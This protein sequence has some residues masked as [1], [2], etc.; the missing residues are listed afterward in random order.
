VQR[1]LCGR[2]LL[3]PRGTVRTRIFRAREFT[4]L[5]ALGLNPEEDPDPPRWG[6]LL[7]ISGTR[8]TE[9]REAGD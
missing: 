7:R 3:F 5:L 8:E 1:A 6:Q 4:A 2:V 9:R